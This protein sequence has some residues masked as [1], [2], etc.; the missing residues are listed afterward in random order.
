[1]LKAIRTIAVCAALAAL[2]A[3]SALELVRAESRGAD[4][5]KRISEYLTGKEN[6]GRYTILRSQP[7]IRDGFYLAFRLQRDDPRSRFHTA[8]L[9]FVRPGSQTEES[10]DLDVGGVSKSRLLIGLTGQPWSDGVAPLAWR[11]EILDSNGAIVA[12][13]QSFLWSPRQ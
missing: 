12:S 8:R 10:I 6:P 2:P 3:A 13:D 11:I 9:H 5:F 7:D 4:S 1:M